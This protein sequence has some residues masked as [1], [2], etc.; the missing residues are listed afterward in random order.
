MFGKFNACYPSLFLLILRYLL[1][2][3]TKKVVSLFSLLSTQLLLTIN[4]QENTYNDFLLI[5][6]F[7]RS[8]ILK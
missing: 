3:V 2:P 4:E 5:I 7:F 8:S 6:N 1:E